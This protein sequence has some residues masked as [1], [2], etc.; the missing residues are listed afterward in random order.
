MTE[1]SSA[2]DW[3]E[4]KDIENV[5]YGDLY[6]PIASINSSKLQEEGVAY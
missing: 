4:R 5:I 3:V 2:K 1:G 6:E